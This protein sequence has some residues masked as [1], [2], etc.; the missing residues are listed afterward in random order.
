M[1]TINNQQTTNDHK[2]YQSTTN[3]MKRKLPLTNSEIVQT[4]SKDLN[5]ST[6]NLNNVD[7]ENDL[8]DYADQIFNYLNETSTKTTTTTS[9][10]HQVENNQINSSS[11]LFIPTHSSNNEIKSFLCSFC[12]YFTHNIQEFQ[13]HIAK[14]TEKNFRCL[15]C[16]C[17][18]KYR[19]DCVTHMK[20]KHSNDVTGSISQ[21]IEKINNNNSIQPSTSTFSINPNL[22]S[23]QKRYGCPYCPLMA[24]S[25]SSIYRHQSRMHT[26]FPKIVHKYS[27]DDPNTR[28]LVAILK[29]KSIKNEQLLKS[30]IPNEN[31]LPDPL[32]ISS[33]SSSSTIHQQTESY[34]LVNRHRCAASKHI[35][36]HNICLSNGRLSKIF[37]CCLCDYRA[38]HRSNVVR[39]VK[40]IHTNNI[41]QSS[42]QLIEEN[43]NK[44]I[45]NDESNLNNSHIEQI[46]NYS[47][48]TIV[49]APIIPTNNDSNKSYADIHLSINIFLPKKKK[50]N[51]LNRT[52]SDCS[53][54]GYSDENIS[55]DDDDDGDG[56][57]KIHIS[58]SNQQNLSSGS[59]YKP[60]KCRRCFYR[61]NWKT[62]MLHHIRLKHHINH[63]SKSDYV[64]MDF[65]SALRSFS[66]YEKTFG[67]VLKSI[68]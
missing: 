7:R 56:I 4:V 39:H 61:S 40:K 33:S 51:L 57:T 49:Q 8:D 24:K 32:N 38:Y 55:H 43:S 21:H 20:R 23:E 1:N 47:L 54:D 2:Q 25:T 6:L 12:P 17:M 64:S 5:E 22:C 3:R 48:N 16:P 67:K 9:S 59:L 36:A 19:R 30:E 65:D 34:S 14:H 11:Q 42:P 62:D 63:A 31:D 29:Q 45:I 50:Y 53:N 60:H 44:L 66:N 10:L 15:L 26:S 27:T 37:Q 46:P 28:N 52:R 18:Y 41:D 35:T 68:F 13:I 58:S